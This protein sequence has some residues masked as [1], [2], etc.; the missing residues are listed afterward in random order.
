MM[1]HIAAFITAL[2]FFSGSMNLCFAESAPEEISIEVPYTKSTLESSDFGMTALYT[3]D[4]FTDTLENTEVKYGDKVY[5][6]DGEK[7][8]IITP[9]ITYISATDKQ[10]YYFDFD[11]N[12][13]TDTER[14]QYN[15]I[16]ISGDVGELVFLDDGTIDITPQTTVKDNEQYTSTA[17]YMF[18][19]PFTLAKDK[20]WQLKMRYT[21]RIKMGMILTP[22]ATW[23]SVSN[24]IG[25]FEFRPNVI[26]PGGRADTNDSA[27]KTVWSSSD[28][29]M[30]NKETDGEYRIY[31]NVSADGGNTWKGEKMFDPEKKYP[32][33]DCDIEYAF[34]WSNYTTAF[35][36]IFDYLY[37][38]PNVGFESAMD[39]VQRYCG[40]L[41]GT[42]ENPGTELIAEA[43]NAYKDLDND[44][45]AELVRGE[46]DMLMK[47][48][49]QLATGDCSVSSFCGKKLSVESGDGT[50]S[51][52]Y[53]AKV[54]V[55][56]KKTEIT[57][58]DVVLSDQWAD[59]EINAQLPGFINE[60]TLKVT[61]A[62]NTAEYII[63][64]YPLNENSLS[65]FEAMV[66]IME[67]KDLFRKTE[68]TA[69]DKAV[70]E[71]ALNKFL[72]LPEA[73]KAEL[74][75]GER[76]FLEN[77]YLSTILESI[78]AADTPEQMSEASQNE[79]GLFIINEYMAGYLFKVRPT[80]GFADIESLN[81]AYKSAVIINDINDG[82]EIS[83][84]IEENEEL[85]KE[86]GIDIKADYALLSDG[87][88]TKFAEVMQSA[89]FFT[90]KTIAR[91]LRESI[92]MAEIK[93]ADSPLSLKNAVMGTN[94]A[95][96]VIN[97]NFELIAA[98]TTKYNA[99]SNPENAFTYMFA[100]ISK[101]T[102]FEDI[103]DVFNSACV[104][105]KNA[106]NTG[107]PQTSYPLGGGGGGGS[108]S[109]R[110]NKGGASIAANPSSVPSN[111]GTS[112]AESAGS[113]FADVENH[114]G[115]SYIISLT[116]KGIISGYEDNTFRPDKTVTRA[117]F[118]KL[119]LN[120]LNINGSTDKKFNDV[121]ENDWY[122][123]YI[124]RAVG[125]GII[126]GSDDNNIYPDHEISREDAAVI[127]YRNI[128]DKINFPN[129]TFSFKDGDQISDYCLEAVNDMA[130]AGIVSGKGSNKFYPKDVMT[131]AE[132]AALISN[133][134]DY[135]Q[136][137]K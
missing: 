56:Y 114:W 112:A 97:N 131:R 27:Y 122:Y 94:S 2:A 35:N 128:K 127:I 41:S 28:V 14:G 119:V 16:N 50:A 67:N 5:A 17:K 25:I 71:V 83:V 107:K 116:G 7:N 115:K 89:D 78:N 70:I 39:F 109:S 110:S 61:S 51:N 136:G 98:D 87:E 62:Q 86:D 101:I 91:T 31:L 45:K 117:E 103:A 82:K 125:A 92:I 9:V 24:S 11:G 72:N 18:E 60:V 32:G 81:T 19:K 13:E 23:G 59:A 42:I 20:H 6:S 74:N 64:V 80:G 118:I 100:D 76:E 123:E 58:N 121:N 133:T 65:E 48:G 96:T 129:K 3:D 137:G 63:T 124:N 104:S 33:F 66:F 57:T 113:S 34:S 126:M 90:G 105:A 134:I 132:A 37:I 68:V 135:I 108:S 30:E 130:Y 38:I 49:K 46:Y 77:L 22:K 40:L 26:S 12:L 102:K 43:V 120:A 99:L 44:V 88:K 1:K 55:D 53:R 8:Y 111:Q 93:Y 85:L 10:G 84:V 15:K 106:E 21:G 52:P 69:S 4:T 75:R 95:G 36:G 73:S 79:L 29:V 54:D 47:L